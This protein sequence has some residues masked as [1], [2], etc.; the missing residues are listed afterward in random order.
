MKTKFFLIESEYTGP[1]QRDSHGNW[2]GD[3]RVMT[4]TT[5]PGTTN[6]SHEERTDGWLGTTN[7]N[8]VTA[9]GEFDTI[10]EARAAAHEMGFTEQS[11]VEYPD[12]DELEFWI[13]PEAAKSQWDAGDWFDGLGRNGTCTEYGITAETTDDELEEAVDTAENEDCASDVVLH[14]TL[15]LFTEL[16]DE[17]RDEKIDS[18]QYDRDLIDESDSDALAEFD[19]SDDGV[20]LI[21]LTTLKGE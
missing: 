2:I 3:S 6:L 16:R 8:S 10:E 1:N 11:D 4:I 14:G 18:L 13:T 17:L 19:T 5:T 15:K 20:L 12:D 9:H 21:K 7:D